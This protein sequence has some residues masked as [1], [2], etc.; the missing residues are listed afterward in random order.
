MKRT[1]SCCQVSI[2]ISPVQHQLEAGE[3]SHLTTS[4]RNIRK[5]LLLRLDPRWGVVMLYLQVPHPVWVLAPVP[6]RHERKLV[7]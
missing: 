5:V 2:I 6:Y 7:H 1:V 4:P 3:S